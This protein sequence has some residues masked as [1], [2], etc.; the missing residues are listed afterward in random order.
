[1]TTDASSDFY[2][3]PARWLTPMEFCLRNR[4]LTGKDPREATLHLDPKCLH[5]SS[6]SMELP[7]T[8]EATQNRPFWRMLM[9]HMR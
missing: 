7:E 8:R 6:F 5:L 3:L 9:K 4:L 1:M 2:I